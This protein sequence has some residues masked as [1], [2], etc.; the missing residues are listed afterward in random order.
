[1]FY[2]GHDMTGSLERGGKQC[3]LDGQDF[4]LDTIRHRE[5]FT[6][7]FFCFRSVPGVKP[8]A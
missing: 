1:M 6:F 3:I 4:V 2:M 8:R 7:N 5:A